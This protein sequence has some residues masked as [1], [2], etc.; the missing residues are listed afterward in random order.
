MF[1]IRRRMNARHGTRSGWLCVQYDA[2]GRRTRAAV[3]AGGDPMT[4]CGLRSAAYACAIIVALWSSHAVAQTRPPSAGAATAPA[5]AAAQALTEFDGSVESLVRTVDPTVVQIFVSGLAPREGVVGGQDDLVTAV[6]ASGSGVIVDSAGFIVTNA[7]VVRGASRIRVEVPIAPMGQSLLTR[8]TQV[9][10]A[11]LVGIDDE[12]DVAVLKIDA[13]N[14]RALPFGDS[15]AIR[16]GQ[17][18][19]AFGSPMGLQ[20]SVSMGIISS[21]ARQLEPESPMVYIQTDASINTGN[22]GG[23]LIDTKGRLIGINTLIISPSGANSGLGFAAPSNIVKAVF[24]QIKTSGRVRRG[25]IGVRAQ[26]V[27]P[28]LA[29]GL[30]LPR[31]WGAVLS[32]VVPGGPADRAGL[33]VGDLIVS[34]DGKPIENGRQLNVTLYRRAVG[35]VVRLEVLR[36]GQPK[37]VVVSVAE[38]PDVMSQ[39]I[40]LA[41]PRENVVA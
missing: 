16:S 11:R 21:V 13:G 14:L 37:T 39:I 33:A 30:K 26:T 27:T 41:D 34:V 25:E 35:D 28:V 4:I 18:V 17:M 2:W 24:E 23:P 5:S 12:T 10:P 36:E 1:A 6:R 9:V 32:D 38:R 3:P 19:L 40:A 20:N 31:D 22:S 15:E 8:R 29:A 7:H